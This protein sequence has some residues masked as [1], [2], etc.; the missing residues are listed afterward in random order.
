MST[1]DGRRDAAGGDSE[2]GI[3]RREGVHRA[4]DSASKPTRRTMQLKTILNHVQR[5][6]GFVYGAA[7]L[8]LG[9]GGQGVLDVPIM[10]RRG[11]RPIC[12]GCFRKRKQYDKLQTRHFQFVP[13]WAMTVLFV[14]TPRRCDCP[15]CG[16]RVELMPWAD[17]KSHITTTFSWFLSS[18]AKLLSWKEVG[19][20]FR[21]SWQVVFNAVEMAVDWGLRHRSLDGVQSI[22][23]DEFA[24]KKRHKYLTMV[25]QIDHHAKRLLWVGETRT[26]ATFEAFF[27]SLGAARSQA[28]R[29]VA[30]DM[31]K[32]FLGVVA[33]RASTAVHVLDRFHV[34]KLLS[35]AVDRVRR[36]EVRDLKQQQK[37]PILAKSRWILLKRPERLRE[38]Q[39]GHLAELVKA[40]LRT[41][42]AYLLKED[43]RPFWG[44]VSA[45][46]AG[47]YLDR[48]CTAA[49]RSRIEPIQ[50]V[51]RTLRSHRGLL[52]NWFAARRAFSHGATEG[53]NNKARTIT[54]R[55]YG[56]RSYEHARIALFHTLGKLPEPP[57][58]THRFW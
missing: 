14:Y 2:L 26:A 12:S 6:P 50:K 5:H 45:F 9:E 30:S 52:L 17:G 53:L 23:V 24:W 54:K 44:Y 22:G 7:K 58:L 47:R 35:D 4:K 34:E 15:A 37:A 39:R 57:W 46:W 51:A 16:V 28:I 40:N 18:W 33:K 38:K 20:R 25:Y 21:V 55:A 13:L 8:R 56:F 49:T 48:W 32:A 31:W 3:E 10:P 43:L 1:D 42:R 36:N 29:F 27:D 41:V 11:S 19:V